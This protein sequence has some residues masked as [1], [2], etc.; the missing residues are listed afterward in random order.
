MPARAFH[1]QVRA[2]YEGLLVSRIDPPITIIS[3]GLLGCSRVDP[4]ITI[5]S[6]GLLGCSRIDPHA[7]EFKKLSTSA[8]MSMLDDAG[9]PIAE[10][11]AALSIL[12]FL[13]CVDDGRLRGGCHS[14]PRGGCHSRS[15]RI[16]SRRRC[17]CR[18]CCC[19]LLLSNC[20][21]RSGRSC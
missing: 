14:L 11:G 1:S 2:F 10:V 9:V 8:L 19:C 6:E 16:L 4:P 17:C 7:Q 3:E 20:E 13:A 5:I 12:R 18:C 21:H 15:P